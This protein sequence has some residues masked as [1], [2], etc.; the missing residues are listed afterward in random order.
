MMVRMRGGGQALTRMTTRRKKSI[1]DCYG[2][3]S[4]YYLLRMLIVGMMLRLRRMSEEEARSM[5]RSHWSMKW[6]S[7]CASGGGG[8][9]GVVGH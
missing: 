9:D 1:G 5:S 2:D 4:C 6:Y 7:G 3:G 8:G